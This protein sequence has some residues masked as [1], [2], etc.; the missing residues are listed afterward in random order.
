MPGRIVQNGAIR[1]DRVFDRLAEM[2]ELR[3]DRV[4]Q[5]L[6]RQ[7]LAEDQRDFLRSRIADRFRQNSDDVVKISRGP[8]PAVVPGRVCG[9]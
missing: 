2:P 6:A 4:H 3:R 1:R 9:A 5:I 7:L 8:Q